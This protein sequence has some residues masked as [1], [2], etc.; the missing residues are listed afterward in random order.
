MTPV[1]ISKLLT[2]V[3]LGGAQKFLRPSLL[4][5]F[6]RYIFF[7]SV[8]GIFSLAS[9]WTYWQ[10]KIW[11]SSELTKAF[12]PPHRSIGYFLSYTLINFY[13]RELIALGV[14]ILAIVAAKIL[15]KKFE[16]RFFWPAEPWILGT[17]VFL[18]G[19]P[20]LWIYL[21]GFFAIYLLITALYSMFRKS[22]RVSS[23]YLWIPV[24][25]IVILISI[26][27]KFPIRI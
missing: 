1:L 7:I 4:L 19:H 25:L 26:W 21:I 20:W 22:G 10:Y 3:I 13:F 15:N 12:L 16:E 18:T 11:D 5:K 23:Y 2:L 24:A 17:A 14:A 8:I 6:A 9:Y 27:F